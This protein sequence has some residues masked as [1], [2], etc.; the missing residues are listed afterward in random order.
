MLPLHFKDFCSVPRRAQDWAF[1]WRRPAIRSCSATFSAA[2]AHALDAAK[3]CSRLRDRLDGR[4]RRRH[5][6]ILVTALHPHHSRRP[7]STTIASTAARKGWPWRP[8][9]ENHFPSSVTAFSENRTAL[10]TSL[11]NRANVRT[12]SRTVRTKR[13]MSEPK[14]KMPADHAGITLTPQ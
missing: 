13:R 7:A 1:S 6:E 14:R 3:P 10:A 11:T 4:L 5:P 12:A 2:C 8:Q 9:A